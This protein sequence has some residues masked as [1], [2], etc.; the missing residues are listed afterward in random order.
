VNKEQGANEN[1]DEKEN[2]KMDFDNRHYYFG[3]WNDAAIF[4]KKL[5]SR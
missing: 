4:Y 3:D 2:S 5:T 1:R